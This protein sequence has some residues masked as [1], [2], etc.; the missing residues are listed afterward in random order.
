M[1]LRVFH[2]HVGNETIVLVPE[3]TLKAM[4]EN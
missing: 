1:V 3:T 4:G 2:L